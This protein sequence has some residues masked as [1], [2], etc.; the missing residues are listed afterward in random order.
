M[1]TG[2][3]LPPLVVPARRTRR[4]GPPSRGGVSHR[5]GGQRGVSALELL[6]VTGLWHFQP[7]P[8]S[9]EAVY[10][11]L[12]RGPSSL[13]VDFFAVPTDLAVALRDPHAGS[14]RH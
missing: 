6:A 8:V 5:P 1:S 11:R 9:D 3:P 2:L 13:V 10:M 7:C 14:L 4:S 12:A